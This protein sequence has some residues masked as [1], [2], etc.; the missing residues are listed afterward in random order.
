MAENEPVTIRLQD[1]QPHDYRTERTELTFELNEVKTKVTAISFIT[2]QVE[3]AENFIL[4]GKDLTLIELKIDTQTLEEGRDYFINPEEERLTIKRAALPNRDFNL[5]VVTE[6]SPI[7][8]TELEGLYVSNGMFCTQ[9]EAQGFRKI[10]YF[11]DRPDNLASYMVKIIGVSQTETPVLLANGNLIES[12]V[13]ETGKPYAIWSD[14]F[15]K[16]CYLFALV[17]GKPGVYED[18]YITKSGREIALKIYTD[19]GN[20]AR[21]AYACDSLKRAMKWDEDVYGLEYDLDLFMIVAVSDFNFGAM[22]NKGLNIFNSK[23][24]LADPE[25]A[26]DA[27]YEAIESIVA[28]EYFHNWTGNR[29]TCRDWFQLCLKEGLTVFRDQ[30]FSADMR[31]HP[32]KRIDDV[33]ALRASQFPEDAGPLAHPVRPESYI[34]INNFYTA[35]VY[36]KGAELCRM[37]RTLVGAEGFRKGTD[38]YFQRFDG[39]AVTVEDFIQAIADANR[40][41]FTRFFTWYRQ[42]GTPVL[43]TESV[44]D[45]SIGRYSLILSQ[46]TEPTPGQPNKQ[47]LYIPVKIAFFNEEGEKV[48]CAF[49]GEKKSEHLIELIAE[50]NIYVFDGFT[51]RPVPSILRDF[52]APVKLKTDLTTE[53]LIHLARFDDNAFNRYESLQ[54]I[55]AGFLS[56]CYQNGELNLSDPRAGGTVKAFQSV[57]NE[58]NDSAFKARTLTLPALSELIGKNENVFPAELLKIRNQFQNYI[59]GELQSAFADHYKRLAPFGLFEPSAEEAGKRAL[60]NLCLRYL[61]IADPKNSHLAR[62]QY[63]LSNNM[64]ACI[65]ALSAVNDTICPERAEMLTE[66]YARFKNEPTVL[67]KWFAMQARTLLPTAIETVQL[68][69]GLEDYNLKNP[70]RV[71]SVLGSFAHG[72]PAYFHSEA[73]YDFIADKISEQDKINPKTAARIAGAYEEKGRLAPELQAAA[74]RALNKI[75]SAKEISK[76]LYEIVSKLLQGEK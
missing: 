40:R 31:S 62:E 63:N 70:N 41:D 21:C 17:A 10:T 29:V 9:C 76:D 27:D 72:N 38:L 2:R 35:T 11:I 3:S 7:C 51:S 30:E 24:I 58:K 13:T 74:N 68:L 16:P 25:I 23:Y 49:E 54:E 33:I 47:P 39:M 4:D 20:E 22:E 69:I 36:E 19:P 37:L 73:G 67:D 18:H 45:E 46:K 15:K 65:G 75:R 64:T 12:G 71:R 8:N 59:A 42:A 55:T 66:F 60:R 50:K 34:E 43:T 53:N 32:V 61:I 28:H 6:I 57:L 56:D 5:T 26:T 44:Y 48:T 1:Y 52:S 14:P